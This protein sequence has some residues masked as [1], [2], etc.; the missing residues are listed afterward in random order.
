[1]ND[2]NKPTI[3]PLPLGHAGF[4]P[5]YKSDKADPIKAFL[6]ARQD[7]YADAQRQVDLE[8]KVAWAIT[9][10]KRI[11]ELANKYACAVS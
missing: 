7:V 9:F 10:L 6:L 11:E 3:G 5:D 8:A 2:A 4:S 1:M